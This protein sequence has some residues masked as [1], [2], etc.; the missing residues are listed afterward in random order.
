[1]SRILSRCF[2]ILYAWA[3]HKKPLG[4]YPLNGPAQRISFN[5]YTLAVRLLP[6][7]R[8]SSASQACT[9]CSFGI[10]SIREATDSTSTTVSCTAESMSRT[11]SV[12]QRIPSETTDAFS[13]SVCGAVSYARGTLWGVTQFDL[14]VYVEA[15]RSLEQPL[16]GDLVG[17]WERET[18]RWLLRPN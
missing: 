13:T 15:L 9:A 18:E 3:T 6:S 17:P 11:C 7:L 8:L 16:D 10:T 1:M 12:R 14:C 4:F 2:Y 5:G